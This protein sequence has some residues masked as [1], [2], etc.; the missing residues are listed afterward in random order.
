MSSSHCASVK[1]ANEIFKGFLKTFVLFG[2]LFLVTGCPNQKPEPKVTNPT[3][4]TQPDSKLVFVAQPGG[5]TAGLGWAQQPV[6]T[7]QDASGKTVTTFSADVTLTLVDSDS[8]S[9][10]GKLEGVNPVKAKDGVAS[11]SG[12][13]VQKVGKYTLKASSPGLPDAMS[14]DFSITHG[15]A[16]KLFFT[17]QPRGAVVKRPFI[18][19]P[20]VEIRDAYGNRVIT[21]A[22]AVAPL[23]IELL[24][25]AAG[26][27]L[28]GN[29]SSMAILGVATW[30]GLS[31]N[32]SGDYVLVVKKPD[33][34]TSGGAG[35]LSVN[36]DRFT[37]AKAE[38]NNTLVVV[39]SL[40]ARGGDGKVTLKWEMPE[41]ATEYNVLRG[42]KEDTLAK[43]GTSK[44]TEYTDSTVENGTIYFYAV[45]VVYAGG[46]SANSQSVQVEP[47][48]VAAIESL[49]VNDKGG[50]GALVVSWRPSTGASG[51]TVK[52]SLDSGKANLGTDGCT[53][54]VPE[55]SC[56]V[57][58]LTPG[59]TYYFMVKATNDHFGRVSS[60][61]WEG[62]PR[63]AP[64]LTVHGYDV[65]LSEK[66]GLFLKAQVI[67]RSNSN[68]RDHEEAVLRVVYGLEPGV[69]P[70][71][72]PKYGYGQL[73]DYILLGKSDSGNTYYF[74]ATENFYN[75][76][77]S[78][79]ERSLIAIPGPGLI[80]AIPG[81]GKVKLEWTLTTGAE[82]YKI[83]CINYTKLCPA[84]FHDGKIYIGKDQTQTSME[85][86]GLTNLDQ[87]SF[88]VSAIMSLDKNGS[89]TV[90]KNGLDSS[91]IM[92]HPAKPEL[93]L[94]GEVSII[95]AVTKQ[96]V[97]QKSEEIFLNEGDILKNIP[98]NFKSA[99]YPKIPG[100]ICDGT[101]A[102][103][104][105]K[106]EV[107][108]SD[109]KITQV[110]DGSG[111][112]KPPEGNESFFTGNK[113]VIEAYYSTINKIDGI[114]LELP[115]NQRA[116]EGAAKITVKLTYG[117]ETVTG[118]F[119]FV[120]SPSK[121]IFTTQPGGGTAG[122][123]WAQQPV[124]TIQDASGKTV[125]TFSA[126]VTLTLVDSDSKS[127]SGKLE[128]VNPVKAK[129][130]VASFSGLSVQKVGKYT[131]KA[132]SPGLPDAMSGDF[133]ITHGV[134]AK[135]FFTKQPR[136]A[137]VKR[138]FISQPIVE[139]RD[140]Y[141]NRVITGADAVA[142][143]TI[144]L[145]DSAAGVKLVGNT[146]SM[147]ILGV[148]TWSGLSI[149]TSGDYVLVVKKPDF[150]TSGGAGAL[151]VNSDRFT[152]AKAEGNNTLVVVSSLEARGG[153][154]KVTLKW[155]MPE[156]A[157]EYNVL[158]GTKEDTLAKVGTSKTTEYTDS[159][160]ENGTI[161]FYAVQVVYA[162][163]TSANSQSVQVEPLA[164]AAIESLVVNDKGGEGALVVSWRPSTGA[165]GY[166][167]KY[168]LDSGKANLGTDGCTVKVPEKSCIVKGLT[169][170]ET[171][172]FMVKAT[173]DHFG[174]VSSGEWEGIP[175]SAPTLTVHGYDVTLSEKEGLFLKAQVIA[176]SNSNFRDHEEAVLRVVYGL[177]PGV[178][179]GIA[180]KY[181][182]S[183]L[184]DYILL[185]K[186]DS[187]NTYYF[188]A[189]EN[190]YNGQLSSA[191]RS[192]IAIPG[193]GLI[194]AIPGDGKVKLEWTLTTGAEGYKISC[195]NYTKL[196][197]APFHDGKIYI[198]KDQTQTSMEATGLTNL[199]QY[200]FSV[201]A[202]MSLDKNGSATVTKNGLD[203]SGIMRHPAKPELSLPGEVSIIRA[204]TKQG[205]SQKSEEIF[206]N[207]G[208]ILKNIPKNFKSAF[209]PKIPGSICDG[210]EAGCGAKIEVSYSDDKITQVIDGSGGVKPPEGNESFFTGNKKV[211]EAYYST[212][213]KI[214]GILL[215]LP[216]NQRA[217]EGAAKITVKLTYGLETVTGEF[218]FVLSPSKLI[219]TTQPGGGTA[220]LGWAQ[221]PVVTIQDASG[222]TVTTFSADVTL[223]LVDSDSKSESGKLEG[224]NP[225]K[226]KDGVASFSGLS[227][228]KVGK[229]T[230]KASSPGLPD[231]MS[232]DFSITHGVAAKLFFTKQPRGA[233]VKRPFISQPIVEIRDAYGNRVITG[234]D[235]VAPLT[236]ELLDS[237]AG[238]KLV[239]NTSSMAILGVATWSGLSINTSG[240][241]VLVVKKPD[242]A[243][244]GGAGALSVNSDRFTNAKAEGNNTLVVV[245]SLEARGGDG[246]VTLKWEM[247][248]GA[249][250]YNVLRGTKEDTLAKVGTS[251]TTEYT[252]STVENGTIY[253]YAVQVVYAG[254]TSANSQSVQVE[255]LA[256]AAIESLVV[257]DKG[258]EGALVVSW[259][260]STGASG[261]TVKYSLDSGKANLGTDGCTVKVPE[262]SCIVK[263]LTPGETYYFMVKATNDHF[264]RV[265]SGEWEGIPRSAPTLTVHGYDVTLS[266]KE[267]LFLK[268]QVIARSNSNFRDHEEAVLRVVY[269][270]EPGVYP[271]IAPKYGHSQLEDYILLGKSD[272]GNTYYFKATE[273]FYNGQLSSAERS[274]IAIP[275]PGL[276]SAIPGDGKVKLEWTLTTGAEGYKISCINY[277]K[278][279]PAPF[280]D[281][282][283][284]IGKDQTQTSMEATGLTNL[285]QYSFSVSAIMSLDKNGSATVTKNGLD[286]SG[287]MRHPAKPELS[288]PGE[289]SIIR[290]VTKQGVSQKS[291]EIF[292]N[293]GDILKNIPKNFKSA[294]YPKIP[295]SICDGTE[296]GC[297][298]KIEVSY[299]DD[300]ITQ[301]IDG[302]GGVKPPEGNES[303]FTGNKKV[304]KAYY[305]TINK[306]DGILLELPVNQRAMEGAAKI[307]VKLTYGLETVTG[308]FQFVLSP[309]KK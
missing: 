99:F 146:S 75:G 179:P 45:Q 203:S 155:E 230:L 42:T 1:C 303:F 43:V 178:Y 31:I 96:G 48:A 149:N 284:Y 281:G 102:G 103:C 210:T 27:K 270:L 177:E 144:E 57:K 69:Y 169:P 18:S 118:E 262:K 290:A 171:Y 20:I 239:G 279:C 121:L 296:A 304:I 243:T 301:V 44:A 216:V 207:E 138:P 193:P 221:Q 297:G 73:E 52:Y 47:L 61:E 79:A 150:A 214:D 115:V 91:G 113:K 145:L 241:Y 54:K 288:L 295:G 251:K 32:T 212:I 276:I 82:G 164:V 280:H 199:D 223:T 133:S 83:S 292:L 19:Q 294:F 16:A 67:A 126:D 95:R 98:K 109:D 170:G 260:P 176:R 94:P 88:S 114:L 153:D 55:K 205:V 40:E 2:G 147:A 209:Y 154:G 287:I 291:E 274:L 84:P 17:K 5:G 172:Y 30:S 78:S 101:E 76:Q 41:G 63:S 175:R 293:E 285:D 224:V 14:G 231:A 283:I 122:L 38:G 278:L 152:N 222:K 161:Y 271:G 100:S 25:S 201:S 108:Y 139:I 267:G 29:T 34:A 211:I 112:V 298:A 127:E 185:G 306:I 9:E 195:I 56:I 111:G 253:F 220:G 49:V 51:Y 277:T 234:A 252:D 125:T 248:E 302:S 106:I 11:F 141:G 194:S 204:V 104:G 192:L 269:G 6:V 39:S 225:V 188:K 187:G 26:V 197:P 272:S 77:L 7:I 286:S 174:R 15:V 137:V 183:Q 85:A 229:Y 166:T 46:T 307:T 180:P 123:G 249:T 168:S 273:N 148:A 228:Q 189:T 86:T 87:Y 242:F 65:T 250:E 142:P 219:F 28:V 213:N 143:L 131:L 160:V 140:A 258:G 66:E 275:G 37:N 227:V 191:E 156:G 33:F 117:L 167:V 162:G 259:R 263:G 202:I 24:D 93:S 119:Q 282:K 265:S 233:V 70:G 218:Q 257:N 13:S 246:K 299:S 50:E 128:G 107:S 124:V 190:F 245:S 305:S 60:G 237:A 129:D 132:S 135:L 36:S 254:G 240:D 186:S 173:N 200:S 226:A 232:G 198:G 289:V 134:A 157:T 255:P 74:K 182:H 72:A 215:E 238:V 158:R 21:G 206:L 268:A 4:M 97:S 22:D 196:C 90:T 308:E 110:I 68:F 116:M 62:I 53:V 264:G 81:D 236:I 10:S 181:G 35:A 8:K 3:P 136:G 12:L 105:A 92:R 184:E 244:S 309:E 159:T 71:I 23:T 247:P 163:G 235:A 217:M 58:G 266:E 208:D 130:G 64:T 300:K 256:V 151:S 80:S 89:A 120:L 261:Y 165:S 59:E